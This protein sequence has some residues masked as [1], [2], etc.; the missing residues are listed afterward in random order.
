MAVKAWRRARMGLETVLG[1]RPQ[2]FFIPYRYAGTVQA[3]E[4]PYAEIEEMLRAAE[5]AF[6]AVLDEIDARAATLA[7]LDGAPPEPRW[8]QDWFA[9]TDAAAAY[10]LVASAPPRRVVEVGSGHSTRFVARALRDSGAEAAHVCIDPAPRAALSGLAVEW[11]RGVLA[12]EHLPLFDA[13]EAGDVAFFDS[14]HILMPGTDVDLILNRILPRLKPG[15][16]VHVH[17]V[18]LPD[19]YPE[20]WAWRG[21]NEQNALAGLLL[22]G[23]F[24]AVFSSRYAATRMGAAERPGLRGLPWTGAPESSL[25][26]MRTDPAS[27][28]E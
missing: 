25:W 20:D 3:P 26:L 2:G 17:D 13:L 22:G 27:P 7:A 1:L 5:P 14:S 28:D 12:E 11:R 8:A 4:R 21:Y 6:A 24:R 23:G 16:R 10:A 15:V 18:F 19:P 9:R